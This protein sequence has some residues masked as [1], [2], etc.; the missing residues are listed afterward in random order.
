MRG[1]WVFYIRVYLHMYVCMYIYSCMYACTYIHVCTHIYI[2]TNKHIYIYIYIYVYISTC[3]ARKSATA[4]FYRNCKYL[5]GVVWGKRSPSQ[6]HIVKR[7][8]VLPCVH[9]RGRRGAE[10]G[11]GGASFMGIFPYWL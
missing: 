3:A 2:Y 4:L 1:R 5:R 10:H 8:S 9:W 7:V 6:G 11:M